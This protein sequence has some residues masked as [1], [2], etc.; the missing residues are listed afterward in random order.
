[1]IYF[2]ILLHLCKSFNITILARPCIIHFYLWRKLQCEIRTIKAAIF[3]ESF[4]VKLKAGT[5]VWKSIHLFIDFLIIFK[6]LVV[7][8]MKLLWIIEMRYCYCGSTC[9]FNRLCFWIAKFNLYDSVRR[10]LMLFIV[11][12]LSLSPLTNPNRD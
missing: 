8:V 9:I 12:T 4:D 10:A 5:L 11:Q 6:L 1:M 3:K 2:H 7:T